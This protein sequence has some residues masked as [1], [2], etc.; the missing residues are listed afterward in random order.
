MSRGCLGRLTTRR[1]ETATQSFST[2][3][4]SAR[5][6]C[7][8]RCGGGVSGEVWP[9]RGAGPKKKNREA[10]PIRSTG[11]FSPS[12]ISDGEPGIGTGDVSRSLEPAADSRSMPGARREPGRVAATRAPGVRM[13]SYE[14][15]RV[16]AHPGTSI[17]ERYRSGQTGQT[18]NLLDHSFG[19]SN[20]PLSTTVPR[21]NSSVG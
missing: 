3:L 15:G 21:G 20:P 1:A 5:P 17:A 18:V 13:T 2:G 6:G 9:E 19:G 7:F 16:N 11:P 12:E 8:K 4:A 14:F 10:F